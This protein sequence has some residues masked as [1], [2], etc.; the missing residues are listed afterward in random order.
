MWSDQQYDVLLQ[1]VVH[2]NQSLC[3]THCSSARNKTD[4]VARVF[5]KLMLEGNVHAAAR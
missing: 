4:D 3:N 5:T 1:E 2:C